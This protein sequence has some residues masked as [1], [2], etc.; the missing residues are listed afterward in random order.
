[1]FSTLL[2]SPVGILMIIALNSPPGMLLIYISLRSPAMALALSFIWDK[3]FCF[4]AYLLGKSVISPVL[5]GTSFMKKGP[6][7]PCSVVSHV[8]QGLLLQCVLHFL[9]CC[10]LATLSSGQSSAEALFVCCGQCLVPGLI[11]ALLPK[12]APICLWIET[13][14][15]HPLN[16]SLT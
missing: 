6:I 16:W 14:F 7:E 1:M 10:V 9:Y 11:V 13:C 8:P 4:F 3:F 2:S 5:E 12:C 15:H